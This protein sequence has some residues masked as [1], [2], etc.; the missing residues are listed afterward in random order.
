MLIVIVFSVN[1]QDVIVLRDAT[2]IQAKVESIGQ[3][4]ITY[5]KWNNLEGPYYTINKSTIFYIKYQN[6]E[7]EI[8]QFNRSRDIAKTPRKHNGISAN[9]RGYITFGSI[10]SSSGAG[11][12]LGISLGGI[13][14][15]HFY[16]AAE[17]GFHSHIIQGG[18]IPSYDKYGNIKYDKHGEQQY[19]REHILEG[20]IPLAVNMKGY[21]TKNK[22]FNPYLNCSLGGFFGVSGLNGINGF[23]CQVG[24][25]FDAKRFTLGI[26]YSGL[27]KH[28]TSNC[29]FVQLGVRFGK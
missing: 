3:N 11:P 20:Y 25:G 12:V 4:E 5:R 8:M 24:A 15:E 10:F 1:A 19:K 22:K 6:G 9:F 29:G 28:G 18:Y 14:G 7:K 27:V 16:L 21:F 26:G 17:S 2:E 23:Y 13:I